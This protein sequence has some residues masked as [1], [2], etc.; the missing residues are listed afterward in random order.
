MSGVKGRSG[1]KPKP[2]TLMDRALRAA[3]EAIPELMASLVRRGI[4]GDKECAIYVIDRVMGRPAISVDQRVRGVIGITA[5]ERRIA[6]MEGSQVE[7]ALLGVPGV[8]EGEFTEVHK[9]CNEA[10]K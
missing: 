6:L 8:I 2:K 5:D 3:N 1:G 7:Q 10:N 4:E 9:P